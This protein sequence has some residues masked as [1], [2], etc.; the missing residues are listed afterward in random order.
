MMVVLGAIHSFHVTL[1]VSLDTHQAKPH[2]FMGQMSDALLTAFSTA[3][4]S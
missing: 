2:R 3:S 1:P 4:S